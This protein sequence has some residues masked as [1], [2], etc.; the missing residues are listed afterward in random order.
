MF[1]NFREK[2]TCIAFEILA[3]IIGFDA[4]PEYLTAIS[5]KWR[6]GIKRNELA[7]DIF[8]DQ[9]ILCIFTVKNKFPGLFVTLRK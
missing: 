1:L 3:L 6:V 2:G 4:D 7:I 5:E 9:Q 8:L